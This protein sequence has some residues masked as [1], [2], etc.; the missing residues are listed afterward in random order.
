[1]I[2]IKWFWLSLWYLIFLLIFIYE[3]IIGFYIRFI[4]C[5]LSIHSVSSF[6]IFIRWISRF[7][8]VLCI[9]S[10]FLFFMCRKKYNEKKWILIFENICSKWNE[11]FISY[12]FWTLIAFFKFNIDVKINISIVFLR[13][14][15]FV[16]FTKLNTYIWISL[17]K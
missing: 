15:L 17:N 12:I 5:Y 10:Y 14:G 11:T 8:L 3:F 13:I 4:F 16:H 2:I 7:R 9:Y 1:M 6:K